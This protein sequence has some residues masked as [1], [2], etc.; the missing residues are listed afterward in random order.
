MVEIGPH[1]ITNQLAIDE[2]CAVG[3]RPGKACTA[4]ADGVDLVI[5][6][7]AAP[8]NH[9]WPNR[10]RQGEELADLNPSVIFEPDASISAAEVPNDD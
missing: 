5:Q 4:L 7:T 1:L 3:Q 10:I 8:A 9:D 2:P 6:A